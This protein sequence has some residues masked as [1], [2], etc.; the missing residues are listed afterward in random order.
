MAVLG[1]ACSWAGIRMKN[2]ATTVEGPPPTFL[3]IK[4]NNNGMRDFKKI[5]M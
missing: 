2:M 3:V 5:T 4:I 1:M